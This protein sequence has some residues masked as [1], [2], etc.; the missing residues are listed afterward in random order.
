MAADCLAIGFARLQDAAEI[1]RL[2]RRRVEHGLRWRYTPK[3]IRALI[4]NRATNVIVARYGREFAGFG[5]M[6]YGIDCANLDLLAV[7]P[8]LHRRGVGRRIVQ[9]LEK[10]AHTA[11]VESVF[12]QVR[13]TNAGALRF[14]QTQGYLVV[15]EAKGYYQGRE[16]AI[17]MAKTLRPPLAAARRRSK[18]SRASRQDSP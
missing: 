17:I 14:Y 1:A 3:R 5:I 18:L 16:S 10:V 13:Q 9:W 4:R 6:S 8:R 7:P 2:S 15:D 12:V 11:G